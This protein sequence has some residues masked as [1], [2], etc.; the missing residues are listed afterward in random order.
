MRISD[1]RVD[2]MFYKYELLLKYLYDWARQVLRN[3]YVTRVSISFILT[4]Q[5]KYI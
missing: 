4:T 5:L 3:L 2:S 1:N